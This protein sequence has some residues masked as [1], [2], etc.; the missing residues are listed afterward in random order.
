MNRRVIPAALL[1]ASL[2]VT[3]P[4][5]LVSSKTKTE[6][7]GRY[8]SEETLSKVEPGMSSDDVQALLGEPT[9]RS[10]PEEGIDLWRWEYSRKETS[11]G[12]VFLVFATSNETE[13]RGSVSVKFRDGVVTKTW[14][15]G[16]S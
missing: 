6:V 8:V 4:A 16:G 14:R 11:S 2:A 12:A 5:C 15:E 9:S 1:L 10:I 3:V 7:S 13:N